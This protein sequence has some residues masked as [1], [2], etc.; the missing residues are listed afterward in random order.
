MSNKQRD[1]DDGR[2]AKAARLEWMYDP[3]AAHA[4]KKDIDIMNEAVDIGKDEEI[5]KLKSTSAGSLFLSDPSKTSADTFRRLNEDPLFAIKREEVRQRQQ[6]INNPIIRNKV[7]EQLKSELKIKPEIK[8]EERR[9][10][11]R[12]RMQRPKRQEISREEQEKRLREML[13][14]G[15]NRDHSKSSKV[16]EYTRQFK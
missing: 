16:A 7:R 8:R 13:Q 6:I 1:Y 12:E 15:K 5:A 14:D 9:S 2:P 3:G 4:D 11:S 10:R